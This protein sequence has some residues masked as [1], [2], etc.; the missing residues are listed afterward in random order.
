MWSQRVWFLLTVFVGNRVSIH[1]KEFGLKG[2]KR[3]ILK[4]QVWIR[5]QVWK[6]FKTSESPRSLGYFCNFPIHSKSNSTHPSPFTSTRFKILTWHPDLSVTSNLVWDPG[7][8][9]CL[10]FFWL[11]NDIQL[12]IYLSQVYSFDLSS[13]VIVQIIFSLQRK[14]VLVTDSQNDGS[15]IIHHF[16]AMYIKGTVVINIFL[17]CF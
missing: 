6:W 3:G 15:F 16:L 7:V 14:F 8:G 11:L 4:K 2:S 13:F 17:L 9:F 1:F 5:D 12:E 10:T